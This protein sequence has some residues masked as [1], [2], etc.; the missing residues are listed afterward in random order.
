M[1]TRGT[2][3]VVAVVVVVREKLVPSEAGGFGGTSLVTGAR[4]WTGPEDGLEA[5]T[6]FELE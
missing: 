2:R 5:L 4:C 3:P 6:V 1:L